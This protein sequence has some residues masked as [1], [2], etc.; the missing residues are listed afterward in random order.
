MDL[1]MNLQG[2]QLQRVPPG[3]STDA[4]T[5][6]LN[7]IIDRLNGLLKT[8][9]F[10][11]GTS[12]RMMI[13]YQK[14]GWGAGQDFG[15]KVSLPGIDV[16]SASDAQLLFKMAL[17][18]WTWR[19]SDGDLVKEFDI[20]GGT[21]FDYN[22]SDGKNFMQTGKLPNGGYGWA[23]AEPGHDVSEGY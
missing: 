6:V 17:D 22:P 21:T 16:A 19:N 3:I 15:I 9:V 8:Q 12:R 7:D 14:D 10:S 18:K 1:G 20:A 5:A 4:Q 23:V 11:D 13:G 2:G